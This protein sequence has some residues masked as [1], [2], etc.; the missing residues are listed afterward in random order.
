MGE[1]SWTC[2]KELHWKEMGVS[3]NCHETDFKGIS[4]TLKLEQFALESV[5]TFVE[6]VQ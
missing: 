6:G 1:V 2:F 3:G 4:C 5:S